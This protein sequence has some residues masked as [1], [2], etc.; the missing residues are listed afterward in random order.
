MPA[1]SKE[2]TVI[3]VKGHYTQMHWGV[4]I[5]YVFVLKQLQKV[6]ILNIDVS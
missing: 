1:Y 2:F 6:T 4:H 5:E 3:L